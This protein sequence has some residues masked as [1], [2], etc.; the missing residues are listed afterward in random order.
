VKETKHTNEAYNFRSTVKV[1]SKIHFNI[2]L[3]VEF[4]QEE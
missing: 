1:G 4:I 2:W 3:W